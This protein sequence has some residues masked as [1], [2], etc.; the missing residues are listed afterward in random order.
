MYR[1]SR[2]VQARRCCTVEGIGSHAGDHS[3]FECLHLRSI[4][5]TR[6]EIDLNKDV[7]GNLEDH[8]VSDLSSFLWRLTTPGSGLAP[9]H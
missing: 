3:A 1:L 7:K 5:A 2:V 6:I 9:L 8:S 4:A